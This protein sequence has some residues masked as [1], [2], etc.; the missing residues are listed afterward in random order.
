MAE[1]PKLSHAELL[2][3]VV[4][5]NVPLTE[6][7][8]DTHPIPELR[9]VMLAEHPLIENWG[10]HLSYNLNDAMGGTD[11]EYTPEKLS[12]DN[13]YIVAYGLIRF[14]YDQTSRSIPPAPIPE[15]YQTFLEER[16]GISIGELFVR[17]NERQ[18][19]LYVE[20]PDFLEAAQDYA[21]H[22]MPGHGRGST[23]GAVA[24]AAAEMYYSFCELEAAAA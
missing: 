22:R 19:D 3:E 8:R 13:G 11:T 7:N 1:V 10:A 23:V 14:S 17:L 9:K 4:R 6:E 12:F 24:M 20:Y 15:D 18:H 21:Q 2:S 16:R 5:L